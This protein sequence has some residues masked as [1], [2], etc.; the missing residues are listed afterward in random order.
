[1]PV[2]VTCELENNYNLSDV[3]ANEDDL[4]N[5]GSSEEYGINTSI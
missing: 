1:M 4:D 5:S 3:L 2:Y